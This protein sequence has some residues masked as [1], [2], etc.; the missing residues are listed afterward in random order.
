MRRVSE[1]PLVVRI[2]QPFL[3][4]LRKERITGCAIAGVHEKEREVAVPSTP[5]ENRRALRDIGPNKPVEPDVLVAAREAAEVDEVRLLRGHAL[6]MP[7]NIQIA[8][9]GYWRPHERDDT[10]AG[11]SPPPRRRAVRPGPTRSDGRP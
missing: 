9:R 6:Q 4:L 1:D 8:G 10:S 5:V 2:T 3:E 11:G 7:Q